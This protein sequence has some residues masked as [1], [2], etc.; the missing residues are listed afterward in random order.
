[1]MDCKN[2]IINGLNYADHYWKSEREGS[3]RACGS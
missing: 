2:D 1:M 3:D